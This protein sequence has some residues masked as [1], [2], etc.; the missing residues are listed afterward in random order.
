MALTIC[1]TTGKPLYETTEGV[2][3]PVDYSFESVN[4]FVHSSGVDFE[5]LQCCC[6]GLATA[7]EKAR[8]QL[9]AVKDW[10]DRDG[11]VGGLSQVIDEIKGE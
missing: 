11:S 4:D 3:H 2:N 9:E 6:L 1:E 5:E 10:Y 8:L 7:L